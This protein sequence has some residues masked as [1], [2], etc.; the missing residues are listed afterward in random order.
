[1]TTN[2]P[3]T[4]EYSNM[5]LITFLTIVKG[6]ALLNVTK[7][8]ED[9]RKSLAVFERTPALLQDVEDYHYDKECIFKPRSYEKQF[10][11]IKFLLNNTGLL[12][13]K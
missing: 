7:D 8:K 1:M 9:P 2:T 12:N 4:C 10:K 3:A 11:D 13:R 5:L 6:H